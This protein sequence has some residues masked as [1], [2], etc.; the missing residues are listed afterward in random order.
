MS[1]VRKHGEIDEVEP[2]SAQ[3]R[4]V[5]PRS[6]LRPPSAST[7]AAASTPPPFMLRDS[8][9]ATPK[10]PRPQCSYI[11][12]K[13]GTCCD[14]NARDNKDRCS[15]HGRCNEPKCEKI[16]IGKTLFCVGHGGG[17]RCNDPG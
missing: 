13:D 17:R 10:A 8:A 11:K 15:A 1:R 7:P 9:G 2:L 5:R 3:R 14:K 6:R 16:A 4:S 12:K